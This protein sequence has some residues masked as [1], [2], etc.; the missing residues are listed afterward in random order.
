MVVR[1]IDGSAVPVRLT[2]A[3]PLAPVCAVL[4]TAFREKPP[5]SLV[6]ELVVA[7]APGWI[8]AL[9]L[10]D[11]TRLPE[12]IE[13]VARRHRAAPHAAAALAWKAYT[14]ALALP[15]VLG[16]ASA[17]RVPLLRPADVL[18]RLDTSRTVLGLGLRPS[19]RVAVLP[20]DPV[21]GHGG[22]EVVATDA[23][24]LHGLRASLLD[25]HLDPL[26]R[27]VRAA[28]RLGMR[29]LLGSL[30][31][32][33][34]HAVADAAEVLPGS[35]AEHARTLLAT[36][37]VAHLVDLTPRPGGGLAV[38]RRTCCLAFTLPEARLC[39]GCCIQRVRQPGASPFHVTSRG[40][41]ANLVSG[42]GVDML[43]TDG[44]PL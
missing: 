11:G 9:G 41:P 38:Q 13:A 33:V 36:L 12:L 2:A 32:G 8:C 40:V 1:Q 17:R 18:V 6:P 5:G 25:A 23:D 27:H 39:A 43:R 22:V 29:T 24:L 20:S 7:D 16:W 19:V 21:A 30:A 31:S 10:A 3:D 14:Y 35:A 37:G 28:T 34:A 15:A 42:S 4:G 44:R 26:L